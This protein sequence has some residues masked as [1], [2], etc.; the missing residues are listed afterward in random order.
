MSETVAIR[1]KNFFYSSVKM[2]IS[3]YIF[4]NLPLEL[5]KHTHIQPILDQ[6]NIE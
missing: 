1:I 5:T 3:K 6:N 4:G 2:H